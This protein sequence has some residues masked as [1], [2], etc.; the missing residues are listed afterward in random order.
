MISL[1]DSQMSATSQAN[2]RLSKCLN[3]KHPYTQKQNLTSDSNFLCDIGKN[4][5]TYLGLSSIMY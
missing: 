3:Q 2:S 4:H 5:F 1:S